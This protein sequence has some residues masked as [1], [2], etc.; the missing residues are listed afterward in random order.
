[1]NNNVET[2]IMVEGELKTVASSKNYVTCD[3]DNAPSRI[4]VTY[5][6]DVSKVLAELKSA[7]LS[8]GANT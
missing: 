4:D 2:N 1:M 8:S 7:I 5:Q 3:T 6:Q